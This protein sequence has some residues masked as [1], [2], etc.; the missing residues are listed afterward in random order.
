MDI[1]LIE[2]NMAP[3]WHQIGLDWIGWD[4][5]GS[6]WQIEK[7]LSEQKVGLRLAPEWFRIGLRLPQ[8]QHRISMDWHGLAEDWLRI[9]LRLAQDW[10]QI[11]MD[12]HGLARMG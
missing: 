4:R 12:W 8:D 6:D 5:I 2:G 9:G 10:H 7:I 11:G 1:L 3:D